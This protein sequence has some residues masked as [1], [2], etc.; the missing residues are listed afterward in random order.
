VY[1]VIKE[2]LGVVSVTNIQTDVLVE[3]SDIVVILQDGTR[4]TVADGQFA[5]EIDYRSDQAVEPIV[6]YYD[7]ARNTILNKMRK[8]GLIVQNFLKV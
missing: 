8:L 3:W 1:L 5:Y 7:K 6:F 2:V 4:F